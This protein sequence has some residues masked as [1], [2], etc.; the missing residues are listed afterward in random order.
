MIFQLGTKYCHFWCQLSFLVFLCSCWYSLQSFLY[1]IE[2]KSSTHQTNF[3]TILPFLKKSKINKESATYFYIIF[4]IRRIIFAFAMVFLY[5]ISEIQVAIWICTSILF[6]MYLVVF[7]PYKASILN[8]FSIF[9]ELWVFICSCSL[10][11]FS[12]I[13]F[14]S[15]Q[16]TQT[17]TT[18][19]YC[20]WIIIV[21]SSWCLIWNCVF[22]FPVKLY[23]T[24]VLVKKIA[25]KINSFI[26][27]KAKNKIGKCYNLFPNS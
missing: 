13:E 26:F 24:F 25:S 3:Q 10:L 1:G 7:T 27:K 21:S 15:N 14:E 16:T 20:G 19:D 5:T 8:R 17:T 18:Q 9:N 2:I 6:L 4:F 12:S 23:E 11:A 22:L